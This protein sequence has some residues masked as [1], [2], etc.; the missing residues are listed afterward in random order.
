MI[1][2]R[3]GRVSR[4][5]SSSGTVKLKADSNGA[6]GTLDISGDFAMERGT[7]LSVSLSEAELRGLLLRIDAIREKQQAKQRADLEKS[8]EQLSQRLEL[9]YDLINSE[10]LIEVQLG[11]VPRSRRE[12]RALK[13]IA[14]LSLSSKELRAARRMVGKN[15]S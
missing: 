12:R 2:Q 15:G 8:S 13:L 3:F 10:P 6:E 5:V 4:L 9:I 11:I 7:G 14:S 1:V